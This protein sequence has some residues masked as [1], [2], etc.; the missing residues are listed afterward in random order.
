[1]NQINITGAGPAGL[2][3]AINLALHGYKVRIYEKNDDCGKRFNNDIQGLENWSHKKDVLQELK[4]LNIDVNFECV[5]FSNILLS[6]GRKKKVYPFKKPLFYAVRRG[7]E[8]GSF[9]QGLKKTALNLGV[10]IFFNKQISKEEANII[11]TGPKKNI[12]VVAKGIVFDAETPDKAIVIVDDKMAYKGYAYFLCMKN[13]CCLAVAL[14]GNFD[15][16]DH[17]LSHAYTTF[18]KLEH[19]PL[20]N[21]KIMKGM[22]NFSLNVFN[23][24]KIYIGEAGGI[25]DLLWG[26]GIRNAL[27]SGFLAAKSI[28]Y[29]LSYEKL[30][31]KYIYPKM[32]ASVANRFLWEL[33]GKRR[34]ELM[35]QGSKMLKDPFSFL[36]SL[37]HFSPLHVVYP[38]ALYKKRKFI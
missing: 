8:D 19:I 31:R 28:V 14:F 22:G 38:L 37:H 24:S 4:E 17:Y 33:M 10:E 5:P 36:K 21:V 16:I 11:A 29:H 27:L 30:I 9:D 7:I 1:M 6:D 34:F 32:K 25:Q 18:T 15:R 23:K 12:F 3:A 35:M 2:S 20:K 26:F 13:H